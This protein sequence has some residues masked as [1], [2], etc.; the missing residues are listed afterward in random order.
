MPKKTGQKI[1]DIMETLFSGGL[2]ELLGQP[3]TIDASHC[4][5]DMFRAV[6]PE[7]HQIIIR[8]SG[9]E[10]KIKMYVFAKGATREQAL[11]NLDSILKELE[12]FAGSICGFHKNGEKTYE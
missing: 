10:L 1:N 6:L 2:K 9:T 3:L 11:T 4:C 5:D 7:G 12:D 8:P